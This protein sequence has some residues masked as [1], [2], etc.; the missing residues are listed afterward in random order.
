MTGHDSEP[1]QIAV[2]IRSA[3]ALRQREALRAALG[4]T[5]RGD[6][7]HVIVT[8]QATGALT[9]SD[10]VTRRYVATLR[11]LGH[12]VGPGDARAVSRAVRSAHA[13]EVWT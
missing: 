9:S 5:L 11:T 2:V 13:I 4:L 7:V 3:D 6:P 8:A 10:P 1:R 12:H